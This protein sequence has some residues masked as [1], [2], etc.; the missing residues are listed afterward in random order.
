M[1]L[2]RYINRSISLH[3]WRLK[4]I[5]KCLK[6]ISANVI[7]ERRLEIVK[8]SLHE[9]SRRVIAPWIEQFERSNVG[10][11][12]AQAVART[13]RRRSVRIIKRADLGARRVRQPSR[14]YGN[15]T[16]VTAPIDALPGG[17][18][19]SRRA[20]IECQIRGK[21]QELWLLMTPTSAQSSVDRFIGHC[22]PPCACSFSR[23]PLAPGT[24]SRVTHTYAALRHKS[25]A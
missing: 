24:P 1:W 20:L 4:K 3:I 5:S 17:E 11:L 23:R 14:D 6:G 19:W 9:R 18:I 10:T 13:T 15:S 7:P 2:L 16:R 22:L 21:G 25:S 12:G 8:L